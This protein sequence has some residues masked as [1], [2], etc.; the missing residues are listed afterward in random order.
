MQGKGA[1]SSMNG[2]ITWDLLG[3]NPVKSFKMPFLI[4][5]PAN[6]FPRKP[7]KNIEDI[8]DMISSLF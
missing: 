7:T 3:E 6:S 2:N 8:T 1:F 4:F 5:S